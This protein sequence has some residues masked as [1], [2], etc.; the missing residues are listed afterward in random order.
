MMNLSLGF[1]F[2]QLSFSKNSPAG[3][4]LILIILDQAI[5]PFAKFA[6]DSKL[7]SYIYSD[8]P[9][10]PCGACLILSKAIELL[11]HLATAP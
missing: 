11:V 2:L 9:K 5:W 7:C 10:N 6:N 8:I 4:F 1:G 3:L